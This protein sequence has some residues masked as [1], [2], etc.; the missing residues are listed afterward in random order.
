[1]YNAGVEWRQPVMRET[2]SAA[3]DGTQSAEL[4]KPFRVQEDSTPSSRCG[5]WSYKI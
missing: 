1:M 3:G 2:V 4:T 5:T